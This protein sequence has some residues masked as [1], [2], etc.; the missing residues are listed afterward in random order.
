MKRLVKL[1]LLLLWVAVKTTAQEI[2]FSQFYENSIIRNP[3]LTGIFSGDYKLGIN[4]KTQWNSISSPY[5]TGLLTAETRI[6]VNDVDDYFSYGVSIVYDQS[7]ST[8]FNSFYL[9][10]AIN[11]NKCLNDQHNSFLSLGATVGYI[12]RSI[13]STKMTFGDQY[14]PGIFDP[15]PT[16]E[17]IPSTKLSYMDIGT[18]L[19]FNSSLGSENRV[20]YYVGL[21]AYHL[22][23]PKVSFASDEANLRIPIKYTGSLGINCFM[24]EHAILDIQGNYVQQGVNREI[25]GGGMLGWRTVDSRDVSLYAVFGGVFYRWNDAWIPTVKISFKQ[26]SF[27]ISYDYNTS[28]LA[29]ASMGKGGFEISLF[30]KGFWK[31]NINSQNCP[32][33]ERTLQSSF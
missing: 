13:N 30:T 28:G 7:G 5:R 12:Q 3:A 26:Y 27:A 11:Y 6:K 4:Y 9:L 29:K 31:R 2:H 14:T 25:I 32:R 16:A 23:R 18:G 8:S 24:G 22:N 33:F 1:I 10:P 17:S 15:S 20:N 21:S 19:S